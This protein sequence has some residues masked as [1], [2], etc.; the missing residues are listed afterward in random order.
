M[1]RYINSDYNQFVA[2]GSSSTLHTGAGKVRAILA[3]NSIATYQALTLYDNTAASG[4]VLFTAYVGAT[5]PLIIILPN[6][7]PLVFST[8]LHVVTGANTQ[9]MI[10]TEA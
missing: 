3:T 4:N 2:A 9:A 8:G 7:L 6:D 5:M 10:I 1:T